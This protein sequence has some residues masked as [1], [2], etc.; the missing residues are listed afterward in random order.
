MATP[1]NC[2]AGAIIASGLMLALPHTGSAQTLREV[3]HEFELPAG[4]G[5]PADLDRRISSY[6]AENWADLFVIAF[7]SAGADRTPLADTLRVSAFDRRTGVWAHASLER[8][9]SAPP[10]WDIGSVLAIQHS[11][12]HLFLDTHTNPSAG[13]V[14]VL[15]RSLRPVAALDGWVLKLLPSGRVFYHRSTPHFVATHPAELWAWD[16]RSGRD[17]RIY[18]G[19]P[20]D[21]VR[22]RYIAS[23][24][25]VY[26]RV[27]EAWFREHNHPMDPEHF[28]SS[29]RSG[30]RTDDTGATVVFL[31]QFGEDEDPTVRTPALDVV[32][33][34]RDAG[35]DRVRCTEVELKA[36]QS[37]HP[38]WTTTR[39]LD[40]LFARLAVAG[41]SP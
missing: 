38:G 13:T 37:G 25:R 27:G 29:I 5:G 30:I 32:V 33:T 16:P 36:L 22:L 35:T 2:L 31:M 19:E 23:T 7:Y 40:D 11:E 14:I 6:S 24:R 15:D 26:D 12:N 28:G 20:Y 21:S 17:A 8:R 1:R 18:P 3:L 10:E 41:P 4:S 39:I 34:C 9:R